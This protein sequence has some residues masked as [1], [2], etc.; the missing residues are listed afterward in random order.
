MSHEKSDYKK[1]INDAR[2]IAVS[3]RAGRRCQQLAEAYDV[4][5]VDIVDDCLR[6]GLYHY[7]EALGEDEND[8]DG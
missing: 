6:Y 4:Q 2:W 3:G 8:G 1:R 5:E 7:E